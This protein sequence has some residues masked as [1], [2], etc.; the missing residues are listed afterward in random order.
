VRTTHKS[1]VARLL[2]LVLTR[3]KAGGTDLASLQSTFVSLVRD[4]RCAV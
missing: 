4:P 1:F 3:L 2:C